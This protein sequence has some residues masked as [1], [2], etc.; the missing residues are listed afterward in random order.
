MQSGQAPVCRDLGKGNSFLMEPAL[1]EPVCFLHWAQDG[2]RGVFLN[3]EEG[4][5]EG[6]SVL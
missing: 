1:P 5:R 2:I 3:R 6:E 4:A